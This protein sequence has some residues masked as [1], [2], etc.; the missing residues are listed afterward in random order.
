MGIHKALNFFFRLGF[1]RF[2]SFLSCVILSYLL[3]LVGLYSFKKSVSLHLLKCVPIGKDH[4]PSVQVE[5][6]TVIDVICGCAFSGLISVDSYLVG[7]AAFFSGNWS[8]LLSFYNPIGLW[9]YLG[10]S[11][12]V[13]I[14]SNSKAG[15]DARFQPSLCWARQVGGAAVP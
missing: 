5:I 15:H 12:L 13:V 10:S 1:W 11:Q 3:F 2:I 8:L 6:L 14:L 9:A 7:V 4:H